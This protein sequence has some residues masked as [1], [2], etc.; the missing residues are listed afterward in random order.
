MNSPNLKFY[1]LIPE[2]TKNFPITKA[3]SV[4]F[5]W[6]QKCRTDYKEKNKTNSVEKHTARCIGINS[7]LKTGWIQ[8]T[9]QDIEIKTNGDGTSFLWRSEI[10]QQ[11]LP[12]VGKLLNHYIDF[13]TPDD[14]YKF[15]PFDNNTLKTVIKIQSPW[16]VEIPKNY[17]LLRIPIP[18]PD[19]NRFTVVPGILNYNNFLNVQIYWHCLNSTE[20]IKKGTPLCQFI[21][22]KNENIDYEICQFNSVDEFSKIYRFGHMVEKI[23]NN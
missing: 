2:I 3:E 22:I 9:Y 16:F 19:D 17:F 5:N 15:R 1:S 10:D 20:I 7:I 6:V 18:Y 8:Y 13:H 4:N 12:E 11:S 23:L 21:L 14:F